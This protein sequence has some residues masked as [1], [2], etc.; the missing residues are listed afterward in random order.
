MSGCYKKPERPIRLNTD[1][2]NELYE[3][4]PY[5]EDSFEHFEEISARDFDL[6][7]ARRVPSARE[8]L[9]LAE[10]IWRYINKHAYRGH[11]T[12]G[13]AKDLI[14][15]RKHVQLAMAELTKQDRVWRSRQGI[16]WLGGRAR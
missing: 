9:D 1:R 10:R 7:E 6:R 5:L 14:V 16:Y 11:R 8:R 2:D 3:S 12:E 4:G 15:P 13:L